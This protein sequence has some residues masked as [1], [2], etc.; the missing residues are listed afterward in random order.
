[1]MRKIVALT[2]I[3]VLM[4]LGATAFAAPIASQSA[5]TQN[6]DVERGDL[7]S[8]STLDASEISQNQENMEALPVGQVSDEALWVI[9]GVAL[10]IAIVV[11]AA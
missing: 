3:V 8:P 5:D 10:L 6:R 2:M 1:M 4:S 9:L 11:I 7:Q